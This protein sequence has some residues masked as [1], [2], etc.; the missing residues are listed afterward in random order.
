MKKIILGSGSPR[1]KEL[2]ALITPEYTVQ[3]ADADETLAPGTPP[4]E[5]VEQLSRLKADAVW[6]LHPSE[7]E[8]L[9]V[10]GADTIVFID[11]QI[12]GKPH[13]HEEAVAMI[14]R[15]SGRTH[16]VCTGVTVITAEQSVTFHQQTEVKFY[17]LSEREIEWYCSLAE[18]YDKAGAYGIQGAGAVLIEGINGDY[19]NVMGLP[20]AKL[21]RALRALSVL[22][23]V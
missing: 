6:A 21:A 20:V 1:R 23:E 2:L 4:I 10:I 8:N 19:F 12:L 14:R 22:P 15:L 11:G 18:P 7:R 5:A 13:S 16:V 9:A 17:A 3:S